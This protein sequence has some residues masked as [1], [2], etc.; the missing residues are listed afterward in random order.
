MIPRQVDMFLRIDNVNS[1]HIAVEVYCCTV[2]I[3]D[4][5]H[6]P[7]DDAIYDKEMYISP[8]ELYDFSASV[9]A[10]MKSLNLTVKS[11]TWVIPSTKQVSNGGWAFSSRDWLTKADAAYVTDNKEYRIIREESNG[12]DELLGI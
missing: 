3:F 6:I 8:S 9:K 5:E 10:D 7:D 11:L 4:K 12:G 2:G 1:K